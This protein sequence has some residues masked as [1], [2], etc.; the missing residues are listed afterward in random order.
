MVLHQ[1]IRIPT[2]VI[3][4]YHFPVKLMATALESF[5]KIIFNL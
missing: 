4:I 5:I 2:P 3:I 1:K